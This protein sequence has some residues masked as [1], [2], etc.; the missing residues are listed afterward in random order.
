MAGGSEWRLDWSLRVSHLVQRCAGGRSSPLTLD[1]I[2]N[3]GVAGDYCGV[4]QVVLRRIA[5]F[6]AVVAAVAVGGC[7]KPPDDVPNPTIDATEVTEPVAWDYAK[8]V[9]AGPERW[10]V[11]EVDLVVE[12]ALERAR[13]SVGLGTP[14]AVTTVDV[15]PS[16]AALL[17]MLPERIEFGTVPDLAIIMGG[18][19]Q[20]GVRF[21]P[22]PTPSPDEYMLVVVDRQTGQ[23]VAQITD[24]DLEYLEDLLPA[25]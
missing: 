9:S 20:L 14:V 4:P 10:D 2:A 19:F 24:D 13:L 5:L 23:W 3:S 6:A 7:N 18:G 21:G 1:P 22:G 8:S 15:Y 25:H 16:D 17:S 12:F 11:S